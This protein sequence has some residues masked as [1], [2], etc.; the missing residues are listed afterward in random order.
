MTES[1]ITF[2]IVSAMAGAHMTAVAT[3]AATA[4]RTRRTRLAPGREP[5][6]RSCMGLSL[7][8]T[9]TSAALSAGPAERATG[10]AGQDAPARGTAH[11]AGATRH[12]CATS[13]MAAA[14]ISAC[15]LR[16]EE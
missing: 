14:A 7:L 13:F 12:R 8:R 15:A 10:P 2:T 1:P 11:G 6:G 16:I 3:T 4:G 5:A 9:G